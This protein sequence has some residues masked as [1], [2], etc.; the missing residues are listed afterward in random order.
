MDLKTGTVLTDFAA[1]LSIE[2]VFLAVFVPLLVEVRAAGVLLGSTVLVEL[3]KAGLGVVADAGVDFVE[4]PQA[5]LGVETGLGVEAGAT[6]GGLFLLELPQLELGL[7][8]DPDERLEL[9]LRDDELEDRLEDPHELPELLEL[10][11]LWASAR[12]G[13]N[14]R[15]RAIK[16]N[17][18]RLN[19]YFF[20]SFYIFFFFRPQEREYFKMLF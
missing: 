4:V 11:L 14:V 18:I 8:E 20:L 13:A 16:I 7:D 9:E 1:A 5:G 15:L 12:V 17:A 6:A 19:I 2:E 10:E 3:P